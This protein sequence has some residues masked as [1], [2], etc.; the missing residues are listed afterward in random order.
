MLDPVQRLRRILLV[1]CVTALAAVPSTLW[2]LDA[3]STNID[4][5]TQAAIEQAVTNNLK[6]Y[7][8]NQPIPGAAVGIWAPGNRSFVKGIGAGQLSPHVPMSVDDKFRIGSNTKTFVITV[9]LQ[10]VQE[11]RL[12]L[13]DTVDKFKLNVNI[14]DGNRITVRQLAQMRSGLLDLYALPA[15]QALKI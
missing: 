9:L 7:G 11:G 15:F 14:P 5:Q 6:S 13:D 2:A 3:G 4:A 1:S 12:S 8:G 10:L